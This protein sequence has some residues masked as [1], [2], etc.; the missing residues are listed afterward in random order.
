M[1]DVRVSTEAANR[2]VNTLGGTLDGGRLCLYA[3]K[4]PL[5]PDDVVESKPLVEIPF[6]SLAFKESKDRSADSF[7]FGNGVPAV[8][9]GKATWFRAVTADGTCILEGDVGT[10]ETHALVLPSVSLSPGVVVEMGSYTLRLP[11]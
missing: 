7:P 2:L 10:G 11:L 8:R 6:P 9:D 5:S 4:R 1:A 3:G